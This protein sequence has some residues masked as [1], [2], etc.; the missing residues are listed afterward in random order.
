MVGYQVWGNAIVASVNI[1]PPDLRKGQ[2]PR[3]TFSLSVSPPA[4][5][6]TQVEHQK[7]LLLPPL[8][9]YNVFPSTAICL[10]QGQFLQ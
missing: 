4:P 2:D 10:V 5:E 7:F 8:L 6:A 1:Q 9:T 3:G